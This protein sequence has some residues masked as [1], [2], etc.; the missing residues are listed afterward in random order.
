MLIKQIDIFS[1]NLPVIGKAYTMAKT[2][3]TQLDTTIVKITSDNG[4][5]GWGETCPVGPV[6][7]ESHATGA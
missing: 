6:Y 5:V 2:S 3:V 4:H 7:T 1:F